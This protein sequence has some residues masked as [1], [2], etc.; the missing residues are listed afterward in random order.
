M[1]HIPVV[2]LCHWLSFL[3]IEHDD[4]LHCLLL[5][6][7]TIIIFV[8]MYV[9]FL[10]KDNKFVAAEVYPEHPYF[11]VAQG[12]QIYFLALEQELQI[13]LLNK[14]EKWRPSLRTLISFFTVSCSPVGAYHALDNSSFTSL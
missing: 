7:Y 8:L 1:Y 12:R 9:F 14:T 13:N 3:V 11:F 6:F 5:E 4:L 2:Y 10:S